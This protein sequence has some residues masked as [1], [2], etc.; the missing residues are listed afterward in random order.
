[1]F[2]VTYENNTIGSYKLA[3]LAGSENISVEMPR[4]F[5]WSDGSTNVPSD[6]FKEGMRACTH[7]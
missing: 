3:R 6:S 7:F 2:G 4:N 5:T 1:M